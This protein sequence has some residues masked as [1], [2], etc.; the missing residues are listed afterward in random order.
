M[1][2]HVQCRKIKV[3]LRQWSPRRWGADVIGKTKCTQ[4]RFLELESST[5]FISHQTQNR[6]NSGMIA[7]LMASGL[8]WNYL[9]VPG[10]DLVYTG[11]ILLSH[12]SCF[13]LKI[14]KKYYPWKESLL[15]VECTWCY[16]QSGQSR[17]RVRINWWIRWKST[18]LKRCKRGDVLCTF[19]VYIVL[20]KLVET[21]RVE[22]LP[23]VQGNQCSIFRH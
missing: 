17:I 10:I 13:K 22:N 11:H 5:D 2:E 23:H 20:P 18:F 4:S 3:D 9:G 1:I 7:L 12:M 21:A 6:Q 14:I 15:S 19:S 16:L 8:Y